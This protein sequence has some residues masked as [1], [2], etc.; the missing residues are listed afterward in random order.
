MCPEIPIQAL[1]VA[2]LAMNA[3]SAE[4]SDSEVSCSSD[5]SHNR[6]IRT[7]QELW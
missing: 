7:P 2:D 4:S 1:G 6:I 3:E 5:S